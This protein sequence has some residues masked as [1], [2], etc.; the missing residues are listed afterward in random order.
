MKTRFIGTDSYAQD[1]SSRLFLE[2]EEETKQL[3]DTIYTGSVSTLY[4]VSGSGKSSLINC[5]LR[6]EL[7]KSEHLTTVVS[8]VKLQ[9]SADSVWNS[10]LAK[11]ELSRNAFFYHLG[12]LTFKALIFSELGLGAKVN[13][14]ANTINETLDVGPILLSDVYRENL[15]SGEAIKDRKLLFVLD[16]FENLY[17]T[18]WLVK[19]S[20]EFTG[21]KLKSDSEPD[22]GESTYQFQKGFLDQVYYL[23]NPR[24]RDKQWSS[25]ARDR[26]ASPPSF[27][28]VI[29]EPELGKLDYLYSRIPY[30]SRSQVRISPLG[31]GPA[32]NVIKRLSEDEDLL[33]TGIVETKP[34]SIPY[35]TV[36]QILDHSSGETAYDVSPF[37]LQLYG[38]WIELEG[39]RGDDGLTIT[40][41]ATEED[42]RKYLK[43]HYKRILNK[44]STLRIDEASEALGSTGIEFARRICVDI[45]IDDQ[46]ATFPRQEKVLLSTQLLSK[47]TLSREA[48]LL[49][50][51]Y[52]VASKILSKVKYGEDGSSE[53][54]ITHNKLVPIIL[55]EVKSV[56]SKLQTDRQEL[57]KLRRE[58][59]QLDLDLEQSR[60]ESEAA[61]SAKLRAEQQRDIEVKKTKRNTILAVIFPLSALA[62]MLSFLKSQE[63]AIHARYDANKREELRNTALENENREEA[64]K[65]RDRAD[66]LQ[67][68]K[69]K[70]QRQ[71]EKQLE[72][73]DNSINISREM[74]QEIQPT[75]SSIKSIEL[76]DRNLQRQVDQL[77]DLVKLG[78]SIW[79]GPLSGPV[80]SAVNTSGWSEL[81]EDQQIFSKLVKGIIKQ[82]TPKLKTEPLPKPLSK[83]I[84]YYGKNNFLKS[85]GT[86]S[87]NWSSRVKSNCNSISSEVGDNE[88]YEEAKNP[89]IIIEQ[90]GRMRILNP[91]C[92]YKEEVAGKAHGEQGRRVPRYLNLRS[93]GSDYSVIGSIASLYDEHNQYFFSLSMGENREFH[94][95]KYIAGEKW[96]KAF[97]RKTLTKRISAIKILD[98]E[99]E[100]IRAVIGTKDGNLL[101]IDFPLVS[102][103]EDETVGDDSYIVRAWE[104]LDGP[105]TALEY[106]RE[107]E[108]APFLY[109]AMENT[110]EKRDAEN[111]LL[112]SSAYLDESRGKLYNLELSRDSQSNVYLKADI[113]SSN[114][115][116]A[117]RLDIPEAPYQ[118]LDLERLDS[119]KCLPISKGEAIST[120]ARSDNNKVVLGFKDGNVIAE[121]DTEL[122]NPLLKCINLG[123]PVT[124]RTE[125]IGSL[126]SIESDDSSNN[127]LAIGNYKVIN[128]KGKNSR[129]P[130]I[131]EDEKL[132][133]LIADSIDSKYSGAI[134]GNGIYIGDRKV[135][136]TT[137]EPSIVVMDKTSKK[138]TSFEGYRVSSRNDEYVNAVMLGSRLYL[139]VRSRPG[140]SG[141]VVSIAFSE[142]SVIS[143]EKPLCPDGNESIDSMN[144]NSEI[145]VIHRYKSAVPNWISV[146]ALGKY[147]SVVDNGGGVIV[148]SP[149]KGIVSEDSIVRKNYDEPIWKS[150]F[151]NLRESWGL[152][153]T[154]GKNGE[155]RYFYTNNVNGKLMLREIYRGNLPI[156]READ[157]NFSID[158][159]I[160]C[161]VRKEC[162]I[163]IPVNS[164]GKNYLFYQELDFAEL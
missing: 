52:F 101:R 119:S 138:I 35:S 160:A 64:Q 16:Q 10:L 24:L 25:E 149:E 96:A 81:L 129:V 118:K 130:I 90:K 14:G 78:D 93:G 44:V 20:A 131:S 6:T 113:D 83:S 91:Q 120:F 127:L 148:F 108:E 98:V 139:G 7:K 49:V 137:F 73:F 13:R 158:M 65:I 153:A 67:K 56:G 31:R 19:R 140:N 132:N 75:Y 61:R 70:Q 72:V 89:S 106:N 57:E 32:R 3:I 17:H 9:A 161:N 143:K 51:E 63:Y 1:T 107:L 105:I 110:L 92:M 55:D 66:E 21:V 159:S 154:L 58:R 157:N 133:T 77:P 144:E 68:L 152:F 99:N 46:Q 115:D 76:L 94:W 100:V 114:F 40:F 43:D 11:G 126:N 42:F 121:V 134:F 38:K 2:R 82:N 80:D 18:N 69:E 5:G 88:V 142:L 156:Y 41:P 12:E 15:S 163:G 87:V 54:K 141:C 164:K 45:L 151:F 47:K 23:T 128:S 122:S 150:E 104:T 112:S 30:A 124:F 39:Q 50:L 37:F 85:I 22:L 97:S 111:L 34:F 103:S 155:T 53:Y 86:S 84:Q 162:K 117:V 62:L 146:D 27:I 116:T 33:R 59:F 135:F 29:T 36:T 71:V 147:I 79:S 8:L 60:A 125:R 109:V 102:K 4:G 123:T 28:I 48:R 145:Q 26:R 95:G 74:L 136:V